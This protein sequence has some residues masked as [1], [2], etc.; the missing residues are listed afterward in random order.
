M[1]PESARL[2]LNRSRNY[3]RQEYFSAENSFGVL[4]LA[5]AM[6]ASNISAITMLGISGETYSRGAFIILFYISGIYVV[7]IIVYVY[8]PVFFEVNVISIYEVIIRTLSC[9][10]L[11]NA[12]SNSTLS[13]RRGRSHRVTPRA[14]EPNAYRIYYKIYR[15]NFLSNRTTESEEGKSE[16]KNLELEIYN[17]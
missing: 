4:P 16:I 2:L 17:N 5:I 10:L 11:I 14:F 12:S 8:L 6:M 1:L 3:R 15:V 9:L 7:P 13:P